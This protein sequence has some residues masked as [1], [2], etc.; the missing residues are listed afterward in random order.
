MPVRAGTRACARRP[1]ERQPWAPDARAHAP[2][3]PHASKR[4][5]HLNVR[6]GTLPIGA[7]SNEH[8][9]VG[10]SDRQRGA[11]RRTRRAHRLPAK[12][13]QRETVGAVHGHLLESATV[14]HAHV[15]LRMAVSARTRARV[16]GRAPVCARKDV[17]AAHLR[18]RTVRACPLTRACLSAL[19]PLPALAVLHILR[20]LCHAL[21]CPTGRTGGA[22]AQLLRCRCVGGGYVRSSTARAR[23]REHARVR[24]GAQKALVHARAHSGVCERAAWH[25]VRSHAPLAALSRARSL[26][27]FTTPPCCGFARLCACVLLSNAIPATTKTSAHTST[28]RSRIERCTKSR[29][30]RRRVRA[31]V[32]GGVGSGARAHG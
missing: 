23:A 2:E 20:A 7:V 27:A 15:R 14:A 32:R 29:L 10:L 3:R 25:G 6:L 5:P 30:G 16:R 19:S 11:K 4:T 28:T 22:R 18:G 17:R 26:T 13:V 8:C 21:R 31:M 9:A 24:M 12:A 1:R